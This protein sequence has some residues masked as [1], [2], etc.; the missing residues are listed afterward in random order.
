MDLLR[1]RVEIH[2]VALRRKA[3]EGRRGG[4]R[5]GRRG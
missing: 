4:N 2:E 5:S 3:E 1:E